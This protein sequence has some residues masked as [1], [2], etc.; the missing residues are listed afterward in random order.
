MVLYLEIQ[1]TPDCDPV[2]IIGV[3]GIRYYDVVV[4]IVFVFVTAADVRCC[5]KCIPRCKLDC[6]DHL[7]PLEILRVTHSRKRCAN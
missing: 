7:Q 2:V 6:S 3:Y 5:L 1:S 4:V